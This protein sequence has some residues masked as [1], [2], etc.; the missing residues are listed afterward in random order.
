MTLSEKQR[1]FTWLLAKFLL[2]SYEQG[3]SF[4]LG[5][6]YRTPEQAALN[7]QK[8]TGIR[9]SLHTIRLAIDLNL[10]DREGKYRPDPEAYAPLGAY[11]K[12][13]H[14]NC[15]W[16]GD[17]KSKDANHFSFEHDGIR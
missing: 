15:A 17:F 8:G 16:G 11:W 14:P 10:F 13:L 4:T 5:E 7:A 2:W 6:A 12:S 1:R 9:K 3:Y